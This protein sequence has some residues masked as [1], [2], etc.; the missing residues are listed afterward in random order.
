MDE[1]FHLRTNLW[2]A[3]IVVQPGGADGTVDG[4]FSLAGRGRGRN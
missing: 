1:D 2:L 4:F 3:D